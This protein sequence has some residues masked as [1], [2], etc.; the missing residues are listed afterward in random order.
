MSDMT[1]AA[2]IDA[3][4]ADEMRRDS[5]VIVL[6][7]LPPGQLVTEFGSQRVRT[8]PISEASFS[9]AAIGAAA[10]GLR[11]VVLWRN[12]TFAFVAFD[13][14]INQ[15]AK[16]RY[17]FGGQRDFPVVFLATVGGGLRL[18]AQHSQSPYSIYAHLAGI[19]VALPTTSAD[20]RGLMTAAI[21]DQDPAIVFVPTR[22]ELQSGPVGDAGVT[23]PFGSAAIRRAG[24]DVSVV[25]FGYML[26]LALEAAER[27][28]STGLSVEVIDPRTVSPFDA[29]TVLGS[30]RR[31][32]R[33]VVV[34]EAPATA[35][36][37]AEVCT[38]VAEDAEAFAALKSP[39]RRVNGASVPVPYS[40]GLEDAV[41]PDV[42]GVLGAIHL[43][44]KP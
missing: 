34:D 8:M 32:G 12:I 41:L 31:T 18:G 43:V 37:A 16:L 20:A 30:V 25:A 29:A 6:G 14:I 1:M 44:M 3:A 21:R 36:M 11:P 5:R 17:M 24:T 23:V 7:T 9:G 39:V 13:A 40:P 2:A 10:A 35:S 4:I 28:A 33:L 38:L 15:A 19:K 42:D 26:A 27:L 22:Y